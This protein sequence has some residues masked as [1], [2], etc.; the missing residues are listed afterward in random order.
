MIGLRSDG[1][2]LGH[3]Y[4]TNHEVPSMEGFHLAFLSIER[5]GENQ[6]Y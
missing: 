2:L 4:M 3:Y 6:K 5:D 1:G